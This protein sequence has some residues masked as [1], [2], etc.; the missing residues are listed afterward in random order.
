[1]F[2]LDPLSV[3]FNIHSNASIKNPHVPEA[4]SCIEYSGEFTKFGFT[5]RI[6]ERMRCRGVKYCPAPFSVAAYFSKRPSYAAAL[7]SMLVDDHSISFKS[8]RSF[9]T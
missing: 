8:F 2:N 4:G 9:F 7:M 5:H 1:M 6:M 3:S